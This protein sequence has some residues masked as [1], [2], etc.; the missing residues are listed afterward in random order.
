MNSINNENKKEKRNNNNHQ[1]SSNNSKFSNNNNKKK[2]RSKNDK[3]S[4]QVKN[5]EDVEKAF[6]FDPND[7]TLRTFPNHAQQSFLN[8]NKQMNEEDYKFYNHRTQFENE[9]KKTNPNIKHDFQFL[10][11]NNNINNNRNNK[12]FA[13]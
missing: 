3:P 6:H 1:W 9:L 4:I 11:V 10:F 2:N 12:Q 7:L 13:F 8:F 5:L